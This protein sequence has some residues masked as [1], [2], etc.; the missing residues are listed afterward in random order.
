M[1]KYEYYFFRKAIFAILSRRTLILNKTK[2]HFQNCV[3][4]NKAPTLLLCA[5]RDGSCRYFIFPIHFWYKHSK[6]NPRLLTSI[7]ISKLWVKKQYHTIY[8]F[9]YLVDFLNCFSFIFYAYYFMF[10]ETIIIFH[11]YVFNFILNFYYF[12]YR[13]VKSLICVTDF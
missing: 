12:L 13:W 10:G 4:S 7:F 9:N 1:L 2:L 8:F 11:V 6:I 3:N 5:C